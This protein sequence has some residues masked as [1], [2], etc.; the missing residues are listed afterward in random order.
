MALYRKYR[1]A[2]FAEVVGQRHVTD[3]LSAAL[4]SRDAQ[5]GPDRINHAYLFSGPRGCGKTSSARI[6]ARS[7]NCV[8]GP[9]A[10]PCGKCA[11][12]RA[13]APGGPG[14]LD[15]IELDAA[16]HNGVEDMRELREKAIFQP[17]E[18]RYRIFIIDEAHM[19]T[20]SGFNALLKIVEEPPEHLI[21]IFATTEPEKVLPTI[22][23]RTHHYPFRLLTPPDMRGL[24]ESIVASEG[25]HV[26][27]DVYP[28]VIQAGGGSPRDSL[29]ILDQLIAGS[30]AGGVDYETSAAILGVTDSVIISDAISALAAGDR[31]GIFSVVNRVIM[32]GQDPARFA[33]DLLGRVRDLLVLSAVPDA[34]EQG[35]VEIPE[36]QIEEVLQHAGG[37]P[38]ATLTRFS[39]VLS[40][41]VR[42]FRGVTSPRLLLEVLCARMLLPA[43]EDSVE[44]LLQRVESLERGL[45]A[46]APLADAPTT[47]AAA[48]AG[49]SGSGGGVGGAGPMDSGATAGSGMSAREAWRKRNAERKKASGIGAGSAPP[50]IPAA[51][52]ARP[53][54]LGQQQTQPQQPERDATLEQGAQGARTTPTPQPEEVVS[55]QTS[56]P[57]PP[58]SEQPA[59]PDDQLSQAERMREARKRMAE[60]ARMQEMQERA[61]M[62]EEREQQT[63]EREGAAGTMAVAEEPTPPAPPASPAAEAEPVAET[64]AVPEGEQEVEGASA[65]ESSVTVEEITQQWSQILDSVEG[66]HAFP[67]RV[68]AE[69]ATPLEID[70][71]DLVIG[72][73][74]GA[75][76]TRLNDAEY[77]KELSAAVKQVTGLDGQVRCVVGSRPRA[78]RAPR[79]GSQN[80]A[81][82]REED[83]SAQQP[84]PETLASPAPSAPPARPAGSESPMSA[85]MQS[86]AERRRKIEEAKRAQQAANRTQSQP[87]RAEHAPSAPHV[88]QPSQHEP[89]AQ[90][91]AQS[92]QL[93]PYQ[94][95]Q[96]A[97]Q[98]RHGQDGARSFRRQA[99]ASAQF[100]DGIPLPPEPEEE[101]AP[102]EDSYAPPAEPYEE[103][104]T[105][106]YYEAVN[107]EGN[108][109]HRTLKDVVIELLEKELGAKPM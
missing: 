91:A 31:A 34:L 64:P 58:Q 26:D 78:P 90:A 30:G 99:E 65:S 2:T 100:D 22:R 14:N 70:G 6:M 45:P 44:A 85:A 47:D 35:L 42:D 67:I 24:L 4:E 28:L 39:Q 73:S 101:F 68:L 69:Q 71:S 109:D 76:V 40:D 105:S 15:V 37:I 38:P 84:A 94:Q 51:P 104:D 59:Q 79:T 43:T 108:F 8:E 55:E 3:P 80:P 98:A 13:L 48:G 89:A 33:L 32:S 56:A 20:A 27:P 23:S 11:S 96:Q 17:A 88:Q 54:P 92:P 50:V 74:T 25:V 87:G 81:Q 19:I 9:T 61:R 52:E 77:A 41:G 97:Q 72:H 12:C 18:S 106:E 5:G 83:S 49:D 82:E 75:L 7:L 93:S 10:T 60:V 46:A 29:S 1:P 57:A 62:A 66:T 36:S 95:A 103:E 102:P 86:I 107:Q 21:F 63:R 16:S 53:E